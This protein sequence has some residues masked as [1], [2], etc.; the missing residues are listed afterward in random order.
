MTIESLS[1]SA[2]FV[3]LGDDSTVVRGAPVEYRHHGMTV[4]VRDDSVGALI[5]VVREPESILIVSGDMPTDELTPLLELALEVS[6]TPVILGLGESAD[7]EKVRAAFALGV[8][9]TIPLPLT[10][11]RLAHLL[12]TTPRSVPDVE[13]VWAGDLMV[14]PGR[15]VVE[16]RGSRI[17]VSPREFAVLLCLARAYPAMVT[18]DDLALQHFDAVADPHA[19]VRVL[20]KRIRARLGEA[21]AP[22][23]ETVRGLGYRLSG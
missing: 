3:V 22:P 23:I 13:C 6:Q 20:I 10:P 2:R 18:L 8:R 14:D 1:G 17:D 16:L 12:R 4:V 5:E 19:S 7:A 9:A 11:E 15:H 21:A